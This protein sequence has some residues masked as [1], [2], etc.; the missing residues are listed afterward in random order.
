MDRK[1]LAQ[2]PL[3]T[4]VI[5]IGAALAAIS[6]AGGVQYK[7]AA[8]APLD[9]NGRLFLGFLALALCGTGFSSVDKP[10]LVGREG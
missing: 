5:I 4:L 6:A 2:L 9:T 1:S 8:L 3:S 10:F 7:E